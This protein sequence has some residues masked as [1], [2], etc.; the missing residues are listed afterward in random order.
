MLVLLVI[1]EASIELS[2]KLRKLISKSLVEIHAWV[3]EIVLST[4]RTRESAKISIAIGA[5]LGS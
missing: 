4:V 3:I 2:G 1:K 5:F